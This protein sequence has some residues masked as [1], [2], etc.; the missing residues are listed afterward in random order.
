[1]PF[2]YQVGNNSLFQ[3]QYKN[4]VLLKAVNVDT[5]GQYY[6]VGQANTIS[7]KIQLAADAYIKAGSTLV[8]SVK[9]EYSNEQDA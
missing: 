2:W 7:N 8:F 3:V 1:M 5:E 6:E 9:G 4:W